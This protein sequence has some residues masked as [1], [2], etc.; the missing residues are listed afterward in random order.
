[1]PCRNWIEQGF[2][3]LKPVGWKWHRTRRLDP[4]ALW[5]RGGRHWL[6]LAIATLLAVAYGT[7]REE[8]AARHREPG[9]QTGNSASLEPERPHTAADSRSRHAWPSHTRGKP[10]DPDAPT[11]S[12]P[13]NTLVNALPGGPVIAGM[14]GISRCREHLC[15]ADPYGVSAMSPRGSGDAR[16]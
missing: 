10:T 9:R 12:R 5:A 8:A 7:R 14:P 4:G 6:V 1:M 16:A 15:F 2:R 3:G 11:D 13:E